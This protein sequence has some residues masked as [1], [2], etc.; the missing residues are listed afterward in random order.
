MD[1]GGPGQAEVRD[2][3]K[4]IRDRLH[5]TGARQYAETKEYRANKLP[6]CDLSTKPM[7]D[8]FDETPKKSYGFGRREVYEPPPKPEGQNK[9]GWRQ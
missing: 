7:I 8:P 5:L 2:L 9:W 4:L 6:L 1:G 3:Q